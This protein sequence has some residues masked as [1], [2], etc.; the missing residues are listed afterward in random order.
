MNTTP[1][2][3]KYREIKSGL[4]K[5]SLLLIRL[6]DFYEAFED[7]AKELASIL[8]ITLTRLNEI[9]IAGFPYYAE[10]HYKKQ[11]TETG[12]TVVTVEIGINKKN[13]IHPD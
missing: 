13:S 6:G 2:L 11:I 3:N 9:P 5:D 10:N 1:L 7:D 12:K 8:N 4:P